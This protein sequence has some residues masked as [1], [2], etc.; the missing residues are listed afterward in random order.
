MLR[1]TDEMSYCRFREC[2][3]VEAQTSETANRR[4]S[5]ICACGRYATRVTVS[6]CSVDHIK[7]QKNDSHCCAPPRVRRRDAHSALRDVS[8][9]AS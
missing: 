5:S 3:G 8:E 2:T 9:H 1:H 4:V 7:V 6:K